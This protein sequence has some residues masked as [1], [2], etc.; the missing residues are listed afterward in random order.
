MLNEGMTVQS[1][2]TGV[3]AGAKHD[4]SACA[5]FVERDAVHYLIDIQVVRLEYPEL[6]RRIIEHAARFNPAAILMED[7]ASGQ[8]LL[9]DLRRETGLPLIACMPDADKLTR[10]LRVTPMMEAGKW[11]YPATRASLRTLSASCLS[12]RVG[13]MTTRSMR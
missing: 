10:L 5:T 13:S 6:R 9:Q 1:W 7:K 4:A 2:D 12:S 11:R 3:K 8:S